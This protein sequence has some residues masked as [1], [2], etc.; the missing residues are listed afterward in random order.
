MKSCPRRSNNILLGNTFDDFPGC[1]IV[2]YP[3]D[4][5]RWFCLDCGQDFV[6]VPP[7]NHVMPAIIAFALVFTLGAI[8]LSP[9]ENSDNNLP[10][11]SNN[12]GLIDR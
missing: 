11:Q 4:R 7:N 8:A 12:Q 9:A 10:Q 1:R 2:R 6:D 5:D 3:D